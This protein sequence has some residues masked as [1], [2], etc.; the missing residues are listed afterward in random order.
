M[1]R[2]TVS[3][4][5]PLFGNALLLLVGSILLAG[6][7]R[8]IGPDYEQPE[9]VTADQWHQQL[10]EGMDSGEAEFQ[11][12]W[13]ALNDPQLNSL[14][15]RASEDSLD[16]RIAIARIDEARASLGIAAGQRYPDVN[17]SGSAQR[18][19]TNIGV[20]GPSQQ[21]PINNFSS[22]GI[23]ASWELDLWGR[24]SRSVESAGAN[25]EASVENYRDVLVVLYADIG[26]NYVLLRTL[27]Q[28]LQY[29]LNNVAAQRETLGLVT[30][31]YNAEL[32][33]ALDLR[34]A[35]LN[36]A[37]TESAIPDLEAAIIQTINRLSVLLGMQPGKLHAELQAPGPIPLPP[38]SLA[39]GIP[40]DLAR[41]RP[42]I[43]RAERNLAAQTATVGVATAGLYPNFFLAGDF[44]YSAIG[45]SLLESR[46]EGWSI[47][48]FFSWNLF[49]GG[50][51]RNSILIEEARTEQLFATYEQTVLRSL[52]DVED[53]LVAF[54][55]ERKREAALQRAEIAALEAVRLVRELYKRGLTDFQN[56]LDSERSL[57][58][59]QDRLADSKGD[60]TLNLISIY[61]ALGGGWSPEEQS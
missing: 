54:A 42:D 50:R 6:C 61:R 4:N 10:V 29:A 58:Q 36:L 33:P 52:Q 60:V 35:E 8:P 28:R 25:Y 22:V 24:V 37:T 57:F 44:G 20:S 1:F 32:S 49:D 5:R 18:Q 40:A 19:S 53:S 2:L 21:R 11:T 48:P 38:A 13:E 56:V 39:V 30:A 12:W 9:I 17:G 47:G 41:R 51:V 7:F 34:Q 26:S 55:E 23:E 15:A 14:I 46:N 59:Q 45:G 3:N 31:R 27:Q 16:I 43:R